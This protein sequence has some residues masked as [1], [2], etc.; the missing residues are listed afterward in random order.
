MA[1][2]V[3]ET[4]GV[5]D[6][7][8][9]RVPVV[10]ALGEM[11]GEVECVREGGAEA[12]VVGVRVSG[13]VRVEVGEELPVAPPAMVLGVGR[14]GEGE[15]EGEE[16]T[17]G[18]GEGERET[19]GVKLALAQEEALTL[20]EGETLGSGQG[21]RGALGECVGEGDRDMLK[22]ADSVGE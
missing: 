15:R 21:V 5:R 1:R 18:E 13:G 7:P 10:V 17:E 6:S 11:V 14:P 2:G 9:L 3:A 22:V 12:E 8:P 20:A 19:R 16:E 4:V